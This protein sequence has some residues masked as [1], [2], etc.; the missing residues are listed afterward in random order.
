[1]ALR[2]VGWQIFTP[3]GTI[4]QKYAFGI[5]WQQ[6]INAIHGIVL[7]GNEQTFTSKKKVEPSN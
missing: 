2:C 7:Y 6:D 1:M 5:L 3:P 4:P